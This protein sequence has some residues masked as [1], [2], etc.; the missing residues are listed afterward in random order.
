MFLIVVDIRERFVYLLFNFVMKQRIKLAQRCA[1]T[2]NVQ[3]HNEAIGEG[4]LR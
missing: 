1:S 2:T 3:R 4:H